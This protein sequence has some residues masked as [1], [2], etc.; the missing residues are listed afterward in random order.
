MTAFNRNPDRKELRSFGL[1][2]G[3]LAAGL[4][5]L[6]LPLLFGR[7]FPAWPWI[8]GGL[9][10]A[11]A[12]AAPAS[13]RPVY[14]AWMTIGQVLGWINTRIILSVMYYLII[15]PVGLLKGLTGKDPMART[16][17]REE[18]SYRKPSAALD[19]KHVERP[20]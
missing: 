9:L 6:A 8:A 13:L 16:W 20:F 18:H 7:S 19:K 12:L 5:G 11:W 14:L 17:S 1:I 2:T 10:I 3:A 4:F 15:V